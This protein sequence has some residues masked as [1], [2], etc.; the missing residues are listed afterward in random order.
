MYP[1][2]FSLLNITTTQ[3]IFSDLSGVK[4]EI[5]NRR[6]TGKFTD[7]WKLNSTFNQWAKEKV[8]REMRKYLGINEKNSTLKLMGCSYGSAQREIYSCRQPH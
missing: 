5:T 6:N 8:I 1:L 4:L 3:N 7:M 2:E